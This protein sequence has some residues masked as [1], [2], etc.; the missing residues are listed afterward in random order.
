MEEKS[1]SSYG[2]PDS[3]LNKFLPTLVT[4]FSQTS[5]TESHPLTVDELQNAETV[6]IKA[7]QAKPLKNEI[8]S[9]S[10]NQELQD[11][12]GR[13]MPRNATSLQKLDPFLDQNGALC[14]GGR[15][16]RANLKEDI[17][18]PILLPRDGHITKL[19]VHK[20]CKHQRRTTTLSEIR[21]NGYWIIG[22]T[23]SVSHYILSCIRCRKLRGPAQSQKMSDLPEYRLHQ[24]PPFTY[25]AV[26]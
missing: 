15:I 18:F 20:I 25:C 14:V 21:S 6:I 16:R 7:T 5:N 8:K 11:L 26:D 1:R 24:A 19:L 3:K 17:N 2:K 23:S 22:G 9:L 13:S 12:Q 4:A 10:K